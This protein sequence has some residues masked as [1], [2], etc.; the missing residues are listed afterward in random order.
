MEDVQFSKLVSSTWQDI[1]NGHHHSF[2]DRLK[3]LK[4]YIKEW[5]RCHFASDTNKIAAVEHEI[6]KLKKQAELYR[7]SDDQ[8]FSLAKLKS[9]LWCLYRREKQSWFQ[10]S[11]LDWIKLEDRN[12]RFFHLIASNRH[13]SNS[14][15]KVLVNGK[16]I[17]QLEE[18]H[19]E[20]V[21]H[22][23]KLYSNNPFL[24]LKKFNCNFKKLNE[25]QRVSLITLFFSEDEIWYAIYD[26]NGNY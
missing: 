16:E 23:S 4:P 11:R 6:D 20:V 26:C 5:Q 1:S 2:F 14:I 3:D 13:R 7:L 21:K 22:F 25:G 10:K 15:E 18:F 8:R 12:T 24:K 17:H 19:A 9:D